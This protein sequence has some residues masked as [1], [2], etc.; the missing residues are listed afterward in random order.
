MSSLT[1][2]QH[3]SRNN[4]PPYREAMPPKA[5]WYDALKSCDPNGYCSDITVTI[6]LY[7]KT[8][9]VFIGMFYP[10]TDDPMLGSMELDDMWPM[11]G[12]SEQHLKRISRKDMEGNEQ[13]FVLEAVSEFMAKYGYARIRSETQMEAQ[14]DE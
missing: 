3:S 12:Y 14:D 4:R 5:W 11:P 8:A 1:Y 9:T 7:P 6:R 2:K 13:H 10:D